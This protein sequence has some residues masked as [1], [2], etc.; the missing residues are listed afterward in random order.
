MLNTQNEDKEENYPYAKIFVITV[1][2]TCSTVITLCLILFLTM[3]MANLS[4]WVESFDWTNML[5]NAIYDAIVGPDP[6]SATSGANANPQNVAAGTVNCL[7]VPPP[8]CN[9]IQVANLEMD[10]VNVAYT[11]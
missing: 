8:S 4:P 10:N 11:A 2:N 9:G 3:F 7:F 5:L 6:N 1:W